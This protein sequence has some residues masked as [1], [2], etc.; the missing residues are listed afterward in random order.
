MALL[1]FLTCGVLYCGVHSKFL[2]NNAIA[3]FVECL[4]LSFNS[5]CN[6]ILCI[7]IHKHFFIRRI[8]CPEE[9]FFSKDLN[10]MALWGYLV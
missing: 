4:H 6:K 7:E 9:T 10:D 1:G 3:I 8:V 2:G 5:F